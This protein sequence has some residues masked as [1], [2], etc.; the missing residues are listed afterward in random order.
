MQLHTYLFDSFIHG[1]EHNLF[2]DNADNADN[3]GNLYNEDSL[4]NY[5]RCFTLA[6]KKLPSCRNQQS[7]KYEVCAT[8]FVGQNTFGALLN[9]LDHTLF[10]LAAV[11]GIILIVH[12][13]A[14]IIL[15][16]G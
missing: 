10:R 6:Q 1:D 2:I 12:T 15:G 7:D 11:F 8:N 9:K 14:L 4:N 16:F 3:A 13:K 5:L